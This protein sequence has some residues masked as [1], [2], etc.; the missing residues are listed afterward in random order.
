MEEESDL[1]ES[2]MADNQNQAAEGDGNT[3]DQNQDPVP[4]DV[5]Q[6]IQVLA[7][8]LS[9]SLRDTVASSMAGFLSRL[10][11]RLPAAPAPPTPDPPADPPAGGATNSNPTTPGKCTSYLFQDHLE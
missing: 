3:S 6:G 4:P 1:S 7:R 2:P 11:A 8:S 10:E 9:A 5:H